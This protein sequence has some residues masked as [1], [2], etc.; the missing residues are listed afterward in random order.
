MI[1]LIQ[2]VQRATVA[3]D[4]EVV[5]AIGRGLLLFVGVERGDT[6]ADAAATAR[7]AAALRCF[8]ED[9][10]MQRSVAD[11]G[12][13][14]LVVSQFTLAADMRRGNRPDFTAAAD[15]VLA[16]RLYLE[17][18]RQLTTCGV[19]VATGRFGAHM[20]VELCNDGPVT[21][22]LAVRNGRVLP[23]TAAHDDPNVSPPT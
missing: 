22:I 12:G 21:L 18:A 10:R 16:E 15:P 5:A 6:S 20:S 17:V 7:K 13:S 8:P 23:R 9:G 1:T 3:V 19:E 11:I 4:G 2:R 14:C